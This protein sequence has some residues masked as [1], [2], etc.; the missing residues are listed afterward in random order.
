MSFILEKSL[1]IIISIEKQLKNNYI[2]VKTIIKQL[3]SFKMI[4]VEWLKNVIN[5]DIIH[6]K[7]YFFNNFLF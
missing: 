7:N 4:I 6:V 3:F 1:K 2:N 5:F